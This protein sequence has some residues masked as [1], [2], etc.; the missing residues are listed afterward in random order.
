MINLITN[1]TNQ[2]MYTGLFLPGLF[3]CS[4]TL[5]KGFASS[6]IRATT[7]VWYFLFLFNTVILRM[8]LSTDKDVRGNKLDNANISP[9]NCRDPVNSQ[10]CIQFY[11]TVYLTDTPGKFRL[12]FQ[13][14]GMYLCILWNVIPKSY[15]SDWKRTSVSI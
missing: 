3:F 15:T 10:G 5:A 7:V 14:H 2:I 6:L 9:Y 1:I 12:D 13:D 4:S 11:S 8:F